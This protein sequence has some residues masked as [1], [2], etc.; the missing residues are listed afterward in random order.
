VQQNFLVARKNIRTHSYREIFEYR[1]NIVPIRVRQ[2][3][4]IPMILAFG[5]R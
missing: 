1:G 2:S 3:L 5:G 4:K